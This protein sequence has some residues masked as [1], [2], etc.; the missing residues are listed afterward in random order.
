ME[1]GGAPALAIDHEC[2]FLPA[3][4]AGLF[5]LLLDGRLLGHAA[6]WHGSPAM[7]S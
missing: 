3:E 6:R 4:M 7:Q 5:N 2:R 1:T